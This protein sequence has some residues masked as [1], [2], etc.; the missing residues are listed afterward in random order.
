MRNNARAGDGGMRL[1]GGDDDALHASFNLNCA[2][3]V[4]EWGD[5]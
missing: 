5:R 4:A 2:R 3:V 1:D